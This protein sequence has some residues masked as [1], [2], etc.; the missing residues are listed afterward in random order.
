MN[1]TVFVTFR[2][3]F[4][5]VVLC[6]LFFLTVSAFDYFCSRWSGSVQCLPFVSLDF[7][8]FENVF[9]SSFKPTPYTL[10]LAIALLRVIVMHIDFIS[11][12]ICAFLRL[13][14]IFFVFYFCC[15]F[16]SIASMFG[17]LRFMSCEWIIL[18]VPFEL[19]VFVCCFMP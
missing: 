9:C 1:Y 7:I 2:A 5:C 13:K 3:L 8:N 6:G 19:T 14:L 15:F 11:N 4:L 18:C 16:L 10:T 12:W 17:L